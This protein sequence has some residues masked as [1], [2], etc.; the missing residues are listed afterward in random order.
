MIVGNT[1][2]IWANQKFQ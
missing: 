1:Y 2:I